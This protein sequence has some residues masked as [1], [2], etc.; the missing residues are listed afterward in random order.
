M[1]DQTNLNE[2]ALEIGAHHIHRLGNP[3]HS[4]TILVAYPKESSLPPFIEVDERRYKVYTFV[5][6]PM[7]CNVCQQFGHSQVTPRQFIY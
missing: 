4:K 7:R 6:K 2:I 5:P 1:D 3:E